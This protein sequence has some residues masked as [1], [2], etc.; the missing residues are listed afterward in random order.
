MGKRRKMQVKAVAQLQLQALQATM[1]Q[2]QP[3]LR[4][5]HLQQAAAL[6]HC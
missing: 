3:A 1:A 2:Q 6:V 5:M 4:G